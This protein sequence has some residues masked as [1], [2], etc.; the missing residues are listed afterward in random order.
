MQNINAKIKLVIFSFNGSELVVFLLNKKLPSTFVSEKASLDKQISDLF[1][2]VLKPD[3]NN[4]YIEQLYTVFDKNNEINIVYFALLPLSEELNKFSKWQNIDKISSQIDD[5]KIIA[6]ATKRLQWKLEYTNIVY[7]LLPEE[8]TLSELQSVY[9]AIFARKLDK[10]NFRKKILSL[11]FLHP[12]E[13][14]KIKNARPAQMY[15]FKTKEPMFIKVF[16]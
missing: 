8:F 5:Y 11:G 6:Y 14:M 2:N 1:I 12:T 15:S 3:L 4:K 10:R 9:E 16:S 7:S 13:K